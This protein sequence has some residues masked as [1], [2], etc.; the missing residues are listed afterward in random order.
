LFSPTLPLADVND[1][2]GDVGTNVAA[3]SPQAAFAAPPCRRQVLVALAVGLALLPMAGAQ[4]ALPAVNLQVQWRWVDVEPVPD[5]RPS[6]PGVVVG[7]SSLQAGRGTQT[8]RVTVDD[9]GPELAQQ[10]SLRNGGRARLRLT[11]TE[12]V[13]WLEMAVLPQGRAAA[14]RQ[15]WVQRVSAMAVRASWPG[16]L[17]SVDVELQAETGEA[18]IGSPVQRQLAT[19][20]LVPPGQWVTVAR[21]V[22][23]VAPSPSRSPGGTAKGAR[24]LGS[25]DAERRPQR[26]LQ[27]R[28]DPLDAPQPAAAKPPPPRP[29]PAKPRTPSARTSK[30]APAP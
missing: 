29:R 19:Q 11:E 27:L 8:W 18:A 20:L 9:G 26:E 30:K 1:C 21:S 15:R 2:T 6:I 13:A 4:A 10:L 3:M 23:D 17:R 16:G 14:L 24:S 12:P 25:R 7:T 22:S 5:E 28:I